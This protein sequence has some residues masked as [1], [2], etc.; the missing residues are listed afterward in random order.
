MTLRTGLLALIATTAMTS[1]ATAE[2]RIMAFTFY[3]SQNDSVSTTGVSTNGSTCVTRLGAGGRVSLASAIVTA[4][5]RDG[6]LTEVGTMRVRYK[7]NKGFKGADSYT[8]RVCGRSGG[9]TGCSTI[10][11]NIT[12]Q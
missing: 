9:G 12:V 4:R 2:C 11:H 3:V 1:A 8:I 7:P 10:T 6:T 5:P